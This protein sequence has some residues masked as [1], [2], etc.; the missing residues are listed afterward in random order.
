MHACLRCFKTIP[1]YMKF[2]GQDVNS[3]DNGKIYSNKKIKGK[4]KKNN[5][6][7][8]CMYV[9]TRS[10]SHLLCWQIENVNK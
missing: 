2:C 7:K 3:D 9:C 1:E 6:S 5:L 4:K 8:L 10:M